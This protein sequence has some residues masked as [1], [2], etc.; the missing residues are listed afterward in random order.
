MAN[1][2]VTVD[3]EVLKRARIRALEQG[4]SVNALVGRML[5]EFSGIVQTQTQVWE[6][7]Q[8][9]AE[10]TTAEDRARAQTRAGRRWKRED[11]YER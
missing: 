9:I 4:T 7:I 11:L 3:D 10:A 6:R 5:A 2:T 8:G 1:L